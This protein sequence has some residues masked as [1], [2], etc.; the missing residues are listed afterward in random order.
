MQQDAYYESF[1]LLDSVIAI[2]Q[3]KHFKDIEA[4]TYNRYGLAY[5]QLNHFK[6]AEEFIDKNTA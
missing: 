6:K 1:T 5:V 4:N 3:R 2:A